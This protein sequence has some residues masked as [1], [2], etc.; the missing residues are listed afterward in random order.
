MIAK[1][2]SS[3]NEVTD[4]VVDMLLIRSDEDALRTIALSFFVTLPNPKLIHDAETMIPTVSYVCIK[5]AAK[6][7][8]PIAIALLQAFMTAWDEIDATL[9]ACAS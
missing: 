3:L 5:V 4:V 7:G 8:E 2:L 9:D 6:L 1:P